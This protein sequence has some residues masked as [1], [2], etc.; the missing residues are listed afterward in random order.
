MRQDNGVNG[1]GGVEAVVVITAAVI[2]SLLTKSGAF[3]V[4]RRETE[5]PSCLKEEVIS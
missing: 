3:L 2:A 4:F 5:T 1:G